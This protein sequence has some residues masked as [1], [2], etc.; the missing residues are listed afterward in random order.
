[1]SVDLHIVVATEKGVGGKKCLPV[2]V[3]L[4]FNG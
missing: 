1:V 3:A 4:H 2:S